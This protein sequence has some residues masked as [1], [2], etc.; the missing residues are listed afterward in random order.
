M[1][2]NRNKGLARPVVTVHRQPDAAE[3]SINVVK[4]LPRRSGFSGTGYDGLAIVV[5]D[6]VDDGITPVTLVTGPPGAAAGR[7]LQLRRDAHRV[8]KEYDAAFA[9]I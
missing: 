2:P 7:H 1:S 6:M 4:G 5:I 8:A 3:H 9:G